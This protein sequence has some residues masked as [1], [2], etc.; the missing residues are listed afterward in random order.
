M[1]IKPHQNILTIISEHQYRN[2]QSDF[3]RQSYKQQDELKEGKSK[4]FYQ[5]KCCKD[6]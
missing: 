2:L 6:S 5:N 1:I 3:Y 4:Y